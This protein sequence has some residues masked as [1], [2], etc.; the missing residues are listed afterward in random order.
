VRDRIVDGVVRFQ[1]CGLP[2]AETLSVE[3]QC[4]YRVLIYVDGHQASSR[5]IWYLCSGS[6]IVMVDSVSSAPKTWIHEHLRENLHYV[7][8]KSDLS[9]LDE[10]IQSLLDNKNECIRLA[11]RSASLARTLFN[12][13]SLITSMANAI[14]KVT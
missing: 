2:L 12:K 10:V 5:L 13:E 11:S 3:E 14:N 4:K 8:V 7:R 6:A 9:N 1:H